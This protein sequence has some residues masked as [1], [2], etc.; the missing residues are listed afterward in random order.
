VEHW[1]ITTH[2]LFSGPTLVQFNRAPEFEVARGERV[3]VRAVLR[4][5]PADDRKPKA[6]AALPDPAVVKALRDLVAAKEGTRDTAKVR[7]AAGQFSRGDVVE[8]EI[9]LT[10][11]RIRLAEAEGNQARVRALL[12]ELVAQRQEQRQ[13]TAVKVEVGFILDDVL[14]E[15]DARLAEAKARRDQARSK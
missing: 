6:A 4:D 15:V 1:E 14:K 7:E 2:G 9:D 5:A 13:L 12:E 11:A 8:A 3:T 10:E